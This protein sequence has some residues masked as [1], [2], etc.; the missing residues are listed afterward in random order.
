MNPV[1]KKHFHNAKTKMAT[2]SKKKLTMKDKNCKM[3]KKNKIKL[4]NMTPD[5]ATLMYFD[6]LNSMAYLT[7]GTMS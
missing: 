6:I 5:H 2:S 7:M 4:M 3:Y 1:L